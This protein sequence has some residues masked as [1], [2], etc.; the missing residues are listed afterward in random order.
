[1]EP[2]WKVTEAKV[3]QVV[4]TLIAVG[5]PK[6]LIIFGSWAAGTSGDDSD[7]DVLVVVPDDIK[8]TLKE[9]ARLRGALKGLIMGIDIVVVRDRDFE[10][11]KDAPGLIY[12]EAL[13]NGRVAYEAA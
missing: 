12:R 4:K 10:Q 11:L 8:N 9:S 1:M 5:R 7:L 6:K 2:I 3:Q 13:R